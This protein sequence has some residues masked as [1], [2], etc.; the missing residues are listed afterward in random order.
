[1]R[2]QVEKFHE[3]LRGAGADVDDDPDEEEGEEDAA[4]NV[5]HH[6]FAGTI[7]MIAFLDLSLSFDGDFVALRA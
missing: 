7:A 1:M 4:I 3:S 5:S 6:T 2:R